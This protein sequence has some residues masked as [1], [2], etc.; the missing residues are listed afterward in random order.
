MAVEVLSTLIG[1]ILEL[2]QA[3]LKPEFSVGSPE[4]A[5]RAA[6]SRMGLE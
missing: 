4:I 5:V 2:C 1:L 3:T 6:C